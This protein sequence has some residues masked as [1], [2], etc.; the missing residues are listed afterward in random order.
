[1]SFNGTF[2]ITN[3]IMIML[4]Q[5]GRTSDVVK[6]GSGAKL[7]PSALKALTAEFAAFSK[8]NLDGLGQVCVSALQDEFKAI[9][10]DE[11]GLTLTAIEV[12]KRAADADDGY[13][14]EDEYADSVDDEEGP[15]E[16]GEEYIMFVYTAEAGSA[17]INLSR[18]G[19]SLNLDLQQMIQERP[20]L[21]WLFDSR[22]PFYSE[23][24]QERIRDAAALMNFRGR[25]ATDPQL[26][27]E[28]AFV[29]GQLFRGELH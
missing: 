15:E 6:A 25:L 5:Y 13:D 19:A 21:C 2:G 23:E 24:Y 29:L 10:H 26:K 28:I 1:M 16:I 11:L 12:A 14:E 7:K 4:R 22:S 9:I 17:E 3:E 20:V 18:T 27:V 8:S